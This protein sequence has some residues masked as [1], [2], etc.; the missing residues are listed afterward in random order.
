MNECTSASIIG[1][2]LSLLFSVVFRIHEC[3]NRWHMS[4][5]TSRSGQCDVHCD[6][7][8]TYTGHWWRKEWEQVTSPPEISEAE[9]LNLRHS[10]WTVCV[11]I[12]TLCK[13]DQWPPVWQRW[14]LTSVTRQE[15]SC[16]WQP[17]L[18]GK[19]ECWQVWPG[20]KFAGLLPLWQNTNERSLRLCNYAFILLWGGLI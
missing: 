12:K 10:H 15:D 18:P 16:V 8:P 20:K 6:G 17:V 11:F 3:T 1:F 2:I 19:D 4:R 5:G 14:L 9:C 13:S 7:T